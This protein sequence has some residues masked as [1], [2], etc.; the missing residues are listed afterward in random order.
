MRCE[1]TDPG[2]PCCHGHCKRAAVVGV[3][4]VDMED[5]TGTPMCQGCADDAMEAGVFRTETIKERVNRT[6]KR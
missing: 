1:C 4:R 5:A 2:C 6:R 3:H